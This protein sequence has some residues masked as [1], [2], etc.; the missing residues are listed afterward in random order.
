MYQGQ[1]TQLNIKLTALRASWNKSW[2]VVYDKA[3]GI[4]FLTKVGKA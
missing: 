2:L 4:I 3:I 1:P